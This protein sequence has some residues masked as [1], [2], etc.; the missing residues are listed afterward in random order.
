MWKIQEIKPITIVNLIKLVNLLFKT[1][2]LDNHRGLQSGKV[3]INSGLLRQNKTKMAQKIKLT[4]L[5]G[6]NYSLIV[7]LFP[8]VKEA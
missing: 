3:E 6:D 4:K 5:K 2:K 7:K 1:I 8:P